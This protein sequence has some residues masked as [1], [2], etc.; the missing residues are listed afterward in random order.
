MNRN[1]LLFAALVIVVLCLGLASRSGFVERGSFIGS[2]SGDTLW[3]M[4]VYLGFA[5]VFA[6]FSIMRL[7]II[8]LIFAFCIELSQLL[9]Y[10][11]LVTLRSY[12]L[13]GLILGYGFLWSDL[14]CYVVGIGLGAT[15][16][17][18]IAPTNKRQERGDI[19]PVS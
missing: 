15:L 8:S 4:M 7:I 14:V 19:R 17:Y 13:G 2:Y 5:M 18:A 3:A 10:D 6:R 12:R 1:R 16:D 11:W 9:K